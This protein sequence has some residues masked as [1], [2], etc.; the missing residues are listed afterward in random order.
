MNKNV[1]KLSIIFFIAMFI[2]PISKADAVA[3]VTWDWKWRSGG[4]V[5][6]S[7]DWLDVTSVGMQS[8]VFATEGKSSGRWY[9]EIDYLKG[10]KTSIIGIATK[11]YSLAAPYIGSSAESYG[12]YSRSG[13]VFM[14]A[15]LKGES[16]S[17]GEQ[18]DAG[19]TIGI[20]LDMDGKTIE[21]YKN[22][23]AQGSLPVEGM[24]ADVYAAVSGAGSF[25]NDTVRAHFKESSFKYPIP[26]GYK[27]YDISDQP[28]ERVV[29][30]N[31]KSDLVVGEQFYVDLLI[32]NG[33]NICAEDLKLAYDQNKFEY[34]GVEDVEGSKVYHVNA[35]NGN[36]RIISAIKGKENV[37]NEKKSFVRVIFKA[38]GEG[39]GKIDAIGC[40]IADN[41]TFERDLLE[42][43]CGEKIFNIRKITDVNRNGQ[44]TL[45]DLGID[46]WY[47]GMNAV[48]TDKSKYDTDIVED[49]KID[50]LDLSTIV[51]SI[52]TNKEYKLNN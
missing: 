20:A 40:R 30:E 16:K 24:T 6:L 46:A 4:N 10:T 33:H 34:I 35:Q 12:Y 38:I 28:Q 11:N 15:S 27:P 45:L 48:D 7:D 44:F 14:Y 36:I 39:T 8:T 17:Y 25:S 37:I 23:K 50:D 41:G 51:S 52:L 19:D 47:Y 21:F 13:D 29:V 3:S 22:G 18:Y 42:L 43:N 5:S 2:M 31:I 26:E 1:L 32:E 9:W 49:G